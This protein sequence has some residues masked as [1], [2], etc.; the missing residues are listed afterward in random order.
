MPIAASSS[1]ENVCSWAVVRPAS[2]AELMAAIW[3]IDRDIDLLGAESL[4]LG[5]GQAGDCR[6]SQR[7]DL[8]IRERCKEGR[9]QAFHRRQC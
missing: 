7:R 3:V 2:P 9:R 1:V 6:R 8:V 5:A 4:E